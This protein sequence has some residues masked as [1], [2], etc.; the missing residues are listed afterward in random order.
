M[1]FASLNSSSYTKEITC[2]KIPKSL[3]NDISPKV[4]IQDP[5]L[6]TGNILSFNHITFEVQTSLVNWSVRRR[7]SDFEWL[8]TIL[9]NQYPKLYIP[10]VPD[11]QM[12]P[13]R[14]ESCFV[15]K[16]MKF[17]QSFI[18]ILIDNELFKASEVL[19]V[20]LSEEDRTAFEKKMTEQYAVIPPKEIENMSNLTGIVRITIDNEENQLY[21]SNIERYFNKKEIVLEK[22]NNDLNNFY[23]NISL[24]EKNLSY[25]QKDFEALHL[26][27]SKASMVIKL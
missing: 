27:N 10:P 21:Q 25:I 24:A 20:F 19:I 11:K 13:K 17:L 22:L 5:K 9:V 3:L 16:R 23:Q 7:Y 12:G 6:S 4:I 15:R 18:D 1:L 8:R 26:L 14:F 2:N